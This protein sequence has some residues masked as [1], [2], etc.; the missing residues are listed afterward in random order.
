MGCAVAGPS[1][2]PSAHAA[3][4]AASTMRNLV[5]IAVTEGVEPLIAVHLRGGASGGRS[6][7]VLM[8]LDLWRSATKLNG[9]TATPRA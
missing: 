4:G 7:D 9:S 1:R 6:Y 2:L 3:A 8:V 5:L